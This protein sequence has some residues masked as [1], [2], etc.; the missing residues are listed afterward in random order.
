VDLVVNVVITL[1]GT[2]LGAI[3]SLALPRIIRRKKYLGQEDILGIWF[4]S[5]QRYHRAQTSEQWVDEKIEID[6]QGSY[7]RIKNSE[8]SLGD[9]Y[10]AL[11][12]LRNGELVGEWRSISLHGG[13]A[14]GSLLLTVLPMGGIIYG[15]FTGPRDTGERVFGVWICGKTKE[16]VTR[17][18]SL[19][20]TQVLEV[21][22]NYQ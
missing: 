3:L 18:K 17:G 12:T 15:F 20:A 6:V 14:Q 9:F 19:I 8:N 7:F 5:Y 4:S 11:V 22:Q 13:H 2:V 16:D 1:G 21:S 10:E